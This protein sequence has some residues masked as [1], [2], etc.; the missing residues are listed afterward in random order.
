MFYVA[1]SVTVPHVVIQLLISSFSFPSAAP[2][3]LAEFY[4]FSKLFPL[5]VTFFPSVIHDL[6]QPLLNS[7]YYYAMSVILQHGNRR[8]PLLLSIYVHLFQGK[9]GL[10]C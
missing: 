4:L 5:S 10:L 6:N 2:C 3:N 1:V 8:F 9:A 7:F